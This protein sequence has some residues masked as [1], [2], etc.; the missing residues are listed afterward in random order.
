MSVCVWFSMHIVWMDV[1]DC[2]FIVL[3]MMWV[4]MG[5]FRLLTQTY[6]ALVI[7]LAHP[8]ALLREWWVNSS[9]TLNSQ[10]FLLIPFA[11]SCIDL[12]VICFFF[13][14]VF[15]CVEFFFFFLKEQIQCDAVSWP[16]FGRSL[17]VFLWPIGSATD[18]CLLLKCVI[19]SFVH[20][21]ECS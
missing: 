16:G 8:S 20:S 9:L 4:L 14:F 2:M 10:I 12:Y 1:W 7:A 19:E 6:K 21:F 17:H 3:K 13:A 18:Y 15:G 11:S 5:I